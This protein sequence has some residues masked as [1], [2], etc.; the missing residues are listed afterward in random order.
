MRRK[1][2]FA[3]G[4]YYHICNRGVEKK[5][6]FIQEKDFLRFIDYLIYFNTENPSWIIN[7][8]RESGIDA[9]PKKEEMLADVVAYC[10]NSNHFHLIL[11]ENKQG[12]I[13]KFMKKICTGYAMYF[14]KKY[15]HVGVL[16]Q[17]RFKSVHIGSN[18]QLLYTSA[19]V[20]CN[21]EIHGF[22]RA[23]EYLWSSFSEYVKD[24]SVVVSGGE[25][26]LEEFE[27][28]EEYRKYALNQISSMR[29]NK[30]TKNIFLE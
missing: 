22:A 10:L 30:E 9:H 4:E 21:C 14:N 18:E 3:I 20:N 12:G 11:K 27:N 7:D 13:A 29:E 6:I 5:N 25:V 26:V 1:I 2:E 28:K 23:E 8:L 17:G 15:N 19:Y 16:F 24:K